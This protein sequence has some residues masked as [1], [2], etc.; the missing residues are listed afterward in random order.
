MWLHP[1]AAPRMQGGVHLAVAEAGASNM[2]GFVADRL[3]DLGPRTAVHSDV[4]DGWMVVAQVTDRRHTQLAA[5]ATSCRRRG[6][7][8]E[9]GRT[10]DVLHFGAPVGVAEG[11]Q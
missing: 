5:R 11:D 4:D 8:G 3:L 10:A 1:A 7:A 9:V 2:Q 6:E